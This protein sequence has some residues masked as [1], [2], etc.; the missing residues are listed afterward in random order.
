MHVT[1]QHSWLTDQ[2][3]KVGNQTQTCPASVCLLV[4]PRNA[5]VCSHD[6][7]TLFLT[8]VS[9]LEFIRFDLDLVRLPA[10]SD[11]WVGGIGAEMTEHCT[12]A[13]LSAGWA[14][15]AP[16]LAQGAEIWGLSTGVEHNVMALG[17]IGSQAC[18]QDPLLCLASSGAPPCPVSAHSSPNL[19]HE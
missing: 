14:V 9:G 10:L 2:V 4:S 16:G 15:L 7:L 1:F 13:Y 11:C 8:L 12:S 3:G 17:L 19:G 6:H 5:L 18:G